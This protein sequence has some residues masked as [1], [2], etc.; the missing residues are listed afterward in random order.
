MTNIELQQEI[1]RLQNQLQHQNLQIQALKS[2]LTQWKDNF[3]RNAREY[4]T[5]VNGRLDKLEER[6]LK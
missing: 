6:L 4:G 3:Q 1:E 2:E 5:Q